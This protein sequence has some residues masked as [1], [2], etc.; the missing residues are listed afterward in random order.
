MAEALSRLVSD[1]DRSIIPGIRH[2][3]VKINV[4]GMA[5]LVGHDF[6]I[7]AELSHE[8]CV[9]PAHH[10]KIDPPVSSRHQFRSS[11]FWSGRT[12][13]CVGISR[14]Q[15]EAAQTR[16]EDEDEGQS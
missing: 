9:R 11:S 10:V 16:I 8:R 5:L 6:W 1:A 13:S 14:H 4:E 15:A 12:R 2:T 3:P 7:N